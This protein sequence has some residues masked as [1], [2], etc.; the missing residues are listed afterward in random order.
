[1]SNTPRIPRQTDLDRQECLSYWRATS[2]GRT[3]LSARPSRTRLRFVA[4][5]PF[6]FRGNPQGLPAAER[7]GTEQ[8]PAMTPLRR[9]HRRYKY[10]LSF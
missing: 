6:R 10:K 5:R 2:V 3:F 4:M 1:M 8:E 7:A 9:F